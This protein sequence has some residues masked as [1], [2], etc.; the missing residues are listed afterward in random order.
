[1]A[2]TRLY[3]G[4]LPF[5]ATD[6]AV[7]VAFEAFGP[8]HEVNLI[9]DQMTGRPRGFGF[10]DMDPEGALAAIAGLNLKDFQGRDLN[11]S[12]ARQRQGGNG[13]N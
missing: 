6:D 1:M 9:T 4:N 3:V 13:R 12:E 5:S 8:V 10:I 2:N 7:R 11:V